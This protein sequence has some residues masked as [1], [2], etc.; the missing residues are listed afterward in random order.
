MKAL[1]DKIEK[2]LKKELKSIVDE[3][4]DFDEPVLTNEYLD[5]YEFL[6]IPLH[7]KK[8]MKAK[9]LRN[10]WN[11]SEFVE[12]RLYTGYSNNF[13]TKSKTS[14]TKSLESIDNFKPRNSRLMNYWK[15]SKYVIKK[16]EK[17]VSDTQIKN[18]KP[19]FRGFGFFKKLCIAR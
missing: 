8:S 9:K 13:K 1:I 5:F 18:K 15:P 10:Y 14:K 12:N 7:M 16:T 17:K 3:T 11:E 4:L 2:T 6:T 19:W